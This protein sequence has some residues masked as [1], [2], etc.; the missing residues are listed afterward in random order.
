MMR[1]YLT[2]EMFGE[3]DI[4]N[5]PNISHTGCAHVGFNW[6]EISMMIINGLIANMFGE[7][8]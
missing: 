2:G 7:T 4:T 5:R 8:N 6:L 1:F 3:I